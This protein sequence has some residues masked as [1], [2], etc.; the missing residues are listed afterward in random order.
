MNNSESYFVL[1]VEKISCTTLA[2]NCHRTGTKLLQNWYKT[3]TK[4]LQ[5]C[6]RTGT[7]LLQNWYKRFSAVASM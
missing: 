5:N 1:N 6:Y 7:K 2:Q 3:V 4:L